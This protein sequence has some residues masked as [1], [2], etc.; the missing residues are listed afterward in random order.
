MFRIS[1]SR[2]NLSY[3]LTTSY[4]KTKTGL[5]QATCKLCNLAYQLRASLT[6]SEPQFSLFTLLRL[7]PNTFFS[8]Y[9]PSAWLFSLLSTFLKNVT[10]A[11]RWKW[12]YSLHISSPTHLGSSSPVSLESILN[13]SFPPLFVWSCSKL[14]CLLASTFCPILSLSF[15]PQIGKFPDCSTENTGVTLIRVLPSGI[16][17]VKF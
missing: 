6:D 10:N 8:C 2:G 11:S 12:E 14:F 16:W 3:P 1:F 7:L 15:L 9:M 4:H 13:S 17:L 5:I